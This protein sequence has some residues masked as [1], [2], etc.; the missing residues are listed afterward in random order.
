[1]IPAAMI[2]S[3]MRSGTAPAP[4]GMDTLAVAIS[5]EVDTLTDVIEPYLIQS[6]FLKHTSRGR[7]ANPSAFKHLGI[8]LNR[9]SREL[10]EEI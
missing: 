4:V 5:E 7:V 10:F 9:K 2:E 1:M 3:V 6:G 8:K